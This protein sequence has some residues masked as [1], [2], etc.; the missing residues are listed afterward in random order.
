VATYRVC[1]NLEN[2]QQRVEREQQ[3]V[4]NDHTHKKTPSQ[5]INFYWE[6]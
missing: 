1:T 4:E 3:S 2:L 6:S 5:T